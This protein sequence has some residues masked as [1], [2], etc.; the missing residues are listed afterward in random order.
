MRSIRA[1]AEHPLTGPTI[2][3]AVAGATV[4]GVYIGI[5][6]GL[7]GALGTPIQVA[8]PIAYVLAVLLHFLLQRRFVFRHVST[9]ALS[10]REQVARYVAM[11][12]VQYPATALSTALLPAILGLSAPAAF[13]CTTLAISTTFFLILRGHV[14]HPADVSDEAEA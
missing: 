13:V 1:L 10:G 4:A 8:I 7:N 6:V 11:G 5:P 14:F 9:F 2:R 3:Y 12:A